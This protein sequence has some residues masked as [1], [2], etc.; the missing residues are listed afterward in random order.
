M[1]QRGILPRRQLAV[2]ASQHGAWTGCQRARAWHPAR[3]DGVVGRVQVCSGDRS[4]RGR[5]GGTAYR[6]CRIGGR[7]CN[8]LHR[9]GRRRG[10]RSWRPRAGLGSCMQPPTWGPCLPQAWRVPRLLHGACNR[11][12]RPRCPCQDGGCPCGAV[13][14]FPACCRRLRYGSGVRRS[15]EPRR[16]VVAPVRRMG[17]L[18][19][20]ARSS[21]V[22][23]L[24]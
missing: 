2:A 16:C 21:C 12:Q 14:S 4:S 15:S 8:E 13:C 7:P 24:M 10:R 23:C 18:E 19:P 17:G 9:R 5:C 11:R 22:M 1:Q 6:P 20:Q 3:E